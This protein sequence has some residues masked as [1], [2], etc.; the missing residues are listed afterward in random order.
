MKK[1]AP[2]LLVL[3]ALAVAAPAAAQTKK[4]SKTSSKSSGKSSGGGGGAGYSTGIGLRGGG[5]A[6]GLTVK[7]FTGGNNV[8]IEGLLTTEY[9]AKGARFTLLF[10]KHYAVLPEFK[11]LQFYFGG[12]AHVGAYRRYYYYGVPYRWKGHKKEYYYVQYYAEDKLYP[13]VGADLVLGLE[14]KI[15]DLPLVV[16]IDYKPYFDIFDGGSGLYNDAAL[17]LRFTF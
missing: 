9:Q 3:A 13:V 2:A 14:Y 1:Y 4:T 7:H 15:D 10:E 8:A 12:G 16:G 6:S 11:H 5:Y 17:S